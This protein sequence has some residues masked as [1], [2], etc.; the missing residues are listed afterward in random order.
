[1]IALVWARSRRA[2]GCSRVQQALPVM[3]CRAWAVA[4]RQVPGAWFQILFYALLYIPPDMDCKTS[5]LRIQSL[6]GSTSS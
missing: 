4:H 6:H 1:M 2:A 3:N 5:G